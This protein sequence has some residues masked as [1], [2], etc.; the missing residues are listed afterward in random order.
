MNWTSHSDSKNVEAG[1]LCEPAGN[2]PLPLCSNIS[3]CA[4]FAW[5]QPWRMCVLIHS[6]WCCSATAQAHPFEDNFYPCMNSAVFE[7]ACFQA[8]LSAV[9]LSTLWSA[10][11][12][13]ALAD[14]LLYN[15]TTN[16]VNFCQQALY[17]HARKGHFFVLKRLLFVS[18]LF[19]CDEFLM[20]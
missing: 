7:A 11:L 15:D 20:F 16:P 13:F 1:Q 10:F 18:T 2:I 17:R 9:Q 5:A 8:L 12:I 3:D 14:D 19:F 6:F 4:D